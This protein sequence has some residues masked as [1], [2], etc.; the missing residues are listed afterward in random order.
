MNKNVYLKFIYKAEV[1]I[2]PTS[3]IVEYR[4]R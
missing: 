4:G 2:H 3:Y 1:E